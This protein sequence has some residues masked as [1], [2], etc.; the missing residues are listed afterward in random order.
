MGTVFFRPP[1]LRASRGGGLGW[2]RGL[3]RLRRIIKPFPRNT[4][5]SF[6]LTTGMLVGSSP[7]DAGNRSTESQRARESHDGVQ[8]F[9]S[10]GSIRSA[11]VIATPVNWWANGEFRD[12]YDPA[13]DTFTTLAELFAREVAMGASREYA[14]P[15]GSL[16][17][18]SG[19]CCQWP[20]LRLR[21]QRR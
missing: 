7:P 17:H 20:D 14:S 13:R 18:R 3:N 10:Q 1:P 12:Q 6:A 11:S 4:A 19:I 9:I 21:R 5:F 8:R 2:G 16:Y 15:D